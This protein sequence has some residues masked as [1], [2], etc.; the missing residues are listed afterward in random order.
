LLG[1]FKNPILAVLAGLIVT[2]VIQSSAASIGMLQ[3]LSITGNI[4]ASVK[5][6]SEN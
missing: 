6:Y 1:S 4:T 5:F 2:A 3:A